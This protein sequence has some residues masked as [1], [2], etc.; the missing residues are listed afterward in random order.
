MSIGAGDMLVTPL[1]MAVA[2]SAVAN[3]GTVYAPRVALR[4]QEP[5]GDVVRR[6]RPRVMGHLP[7]SLPDLGFVRE[8]LRGVVGEDGTAA[9]AFAGF[10]FHRV[11]VGGKTGTADPKANNREDH[12][13]FAAMAPVNDPQ[14]VVVVIVEEAGF[15]SVTA[16]PV[17][18]RILEG[19]FDLPITDLHLG[20]AAD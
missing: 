1:Q 8:A 13:W 11:S 6:I 2:Y 5:D 7:F 19:L 12:S 18:R 10:P 14:Y 9:S 3:G 17:V 20:E 4:V 16:A 15:G